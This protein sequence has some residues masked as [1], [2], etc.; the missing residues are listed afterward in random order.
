ML[1]GESY[2]KLVLIGGK[3]IDDETQEQVNQD[4]EKE[5]A[6]RRQQQKKSP[7]VTKYFNVSPA[8]IEQLEQL[9]DTKVIGEETVLGRKTWR[10]ESVPKR[11]LRP[12]DKE[13]DKEEVATAIT[14][15]VTW[16]DR[17]DGVEIKQT[18]TFA[19]A[20][21]DIHV[22]TEL[23]VEFSK[24]VEAWLPGTFRARFDYKTGLMQHSFTESDGRRYD[25]KRFTA[26][27]R[28]VTP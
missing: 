3:P 22:G 2:R 8:G 19:S 10:L 7:T 18:S 24:V 16:I 25:Y 9:F 4:L 26:D 13:I 21:R 11:N 5:R 14:R 6:K 20:F 27:S 15:V 23:T 28:I 1:E 12:A 17:Q